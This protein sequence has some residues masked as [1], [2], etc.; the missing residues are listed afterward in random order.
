MTVSV[1]SLRVAHCD[2]AGSLRMPSVVKHRFGFPKELFWVSTKMHLASRI[3][4]T[5]LPI[6]VHLLLL[7][8]PKGAGGET[9]CVSDDSLW[10]R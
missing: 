1:A 8:G 3:F 6:I 9:L 10:L 7:H 4:S 2:K 5:S